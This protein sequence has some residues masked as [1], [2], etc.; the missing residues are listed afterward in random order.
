MLAVASVAGAV[1]VAAVAQ[2]G[3]D[4]MRAVGPISTKNGFPIWYADKDGTEVELC[5][6]GTPLCRFLPGDVPDPNSPIAFP[7][8]FPGE[9][10]WW[11]GESTIADGLTKKVVLVMQVCANLR[12]KV[13]CTLVVAPPRVPRSAPSAGTTTNV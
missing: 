11:A 1:G 8:N 2:G 3:A 7:G 5:L 9:A 12:A 4:D 10:F 13:N 6:D